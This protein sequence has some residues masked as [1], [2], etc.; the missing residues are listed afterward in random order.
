ML[1][2]PPTSD[3]HPDDTGVNVPAAQLVQDDD[4]EDAE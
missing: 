2:P 3:A 1:Q 4:P